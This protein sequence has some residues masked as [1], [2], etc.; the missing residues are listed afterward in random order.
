[1]SKNP[2]FYFDKIITILMNITKEQVFVL[3]VF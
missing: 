2:L 1:V 3:L